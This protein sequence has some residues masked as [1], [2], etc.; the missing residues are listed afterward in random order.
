VDAPEARYLERDGALLAYQV[1]GDHGADVLMIGEAA[2]HF[3]LAWTDP[4]IHE[5]YDR[6]AAFSRTA[7]MQMRGLG[8]S[9]PIR[10]F[11]TLEQQ[12]DDVLAVLD[13][14]GMPRATLVGSLTTCGA[15]VLAAAKA[16]ERVASLV[17]FKAIG[18]GPLAANAR[19][20]GWPADE[21]AEYAAGWRAV[22]QRWG[23]GAT[24]EMWDP[25][26]ATPYNR[27]LMAMLER[28]SA[29]P[30]FAQTYVDAAMSLDYSEF[31]PA[32]QAPTRVLYAPTGREPEEVVRRVAELIPNAT[33]HALPITPPGAA[34]G[35]AYLAVWEQVEEVATGVPH[36]DG[37]DRFL[38]TVL[39]TD[40][41]ASTEL[42]ARIGDSK[43]RELRAAHERQVR[44]HV[45]E[46][47]GR[48]VSVTGDGTFSLFDG[49]TKAVRC[50]DH[51]CRGAADL[52]VEVRA[53]VH[54]GEL[55]RTGHDVTGLAVHIGA[56]IGA[57][58]APGEVLVSRTVVD[59]V[60]GSGLEFAERGAHQLKGV[61]GQWPLYLLAD[62]ARRPV[63]LADDRSLETPLD[64][65][66]LRT[67]RTA[68]RA[69]RAALRIGNAVQRRRARAR[70][71]AG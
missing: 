14:A 9:E 56:R 60:T 49:P 53:G 42:L 2:Q 47:G 1:V 64:R 33:F 40:L 7:F 6:S 17:L 48:L 16:P 71:T 54:T 27:R 35:E 52:G 3:D 30:A 26:L 41:V 12:A 66:A 20:Y 58:A 37:T 22:L 61:P 63:P 24:L 13:A 29:T 10:Y 70:A 51:I 46:A 45:E 67:A 69:M 68:P 21:A 43:Y 18:C 11:P 4:Y 15:V 28:C 59:L 62:A 55:E 44:L 65:A 31:L 25:V 38:G 8:L 50:A 39:F 36:Q 32:V 23:S 5:L 57:L 34:I 19:Q